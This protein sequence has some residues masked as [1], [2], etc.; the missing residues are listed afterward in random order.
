[1]AREIKLPQMAM[2]CNDG[3]VTSWKVKVGDQV[4]VGD[5]LCEAEEEKVT[6][7]ILSPIN[8]TV[9]KIC[10]EEGV[11]VPVLT[12]LCIIGEPGEEIE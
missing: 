7:S 3:E 6:D 11:N 5:V 1:M 10:V 12:T 8:G 2:L 9:L 4:K